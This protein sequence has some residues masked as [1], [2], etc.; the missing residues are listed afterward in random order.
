M[1]AV[2]D[3]IA[4]AETTGERFYSAE[5]YRLH[6]ELLAQQSISQCENAEA[7][8]RRAINIANQQGALSLERKARVSLRHWIG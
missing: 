2:K 8:F 1:K 5:L 7:E 4:V 3:A 6:S